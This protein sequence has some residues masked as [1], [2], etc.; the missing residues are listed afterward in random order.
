MAK[1]HLKSESEFPQ[2]PTVKPNSGFGEILQKFPHFLEI[3]S[4][5]YNKSVGKIYLKF[6]L[7]K[8]NWNK[9]F[10]NY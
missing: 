6:F 7:K 9:T 2:K 1:E 10:I 8:K 4:M 3:L 5:K